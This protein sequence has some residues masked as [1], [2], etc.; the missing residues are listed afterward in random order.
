MENTILLARFWGSLL[1]ILGVMSFGAG[2]LRRVIEYT[3]DRT[4]TVSTGY[5]TMLLGLITVVM[6]NIWVWNWPVVITILGWSTLIKGIIK[7]GFPGQINKQAQ[8]FKGQA[9]LWGIAIFL[10]GAFIFWIGLN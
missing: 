3:E 8:I 10:I 1:M 7:I 9:T 5:I 6:H 4:I 2:F